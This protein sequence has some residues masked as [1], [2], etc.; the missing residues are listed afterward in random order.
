MPNWPCFNKN[1]LAWQPPVGDSDVTCV[2]YDE[3]EVASADTAPA[4][5]PDVI[6]ANIARLEAKRLGTSKSTKAK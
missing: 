2:E 4:V 5:A 6:A 3:V 1:S